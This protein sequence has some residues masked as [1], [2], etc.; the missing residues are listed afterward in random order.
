MHH[1]FRSYL[2]I[3]LFYSGVVFPNS[4]FCMQL[5]LLYINILSSDSFFLASI[6]TYLTI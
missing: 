4:T 1:F 5:E 2:F 6:L 3:E